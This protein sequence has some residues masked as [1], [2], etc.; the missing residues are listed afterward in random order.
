MREEKRLTKRPR[1]Q[2]AQV[3]PPPLPA[4]A[5]AGAAHGKAGASRTGKEDLFCRQ[6]V[7][8][9]KEPKSRQRL[10]F[11]GTGRRTAWWQPMQ[12]AEQ[13]QLST[14]AARDE[15]TPGE[16]FL[17]LPAA[18]SSPHLPIKILP[19]GSPGHR[20]PSGLTPCSQA[21]RQPTEKTYAAINRPALN[22]STCST[23]RQRR[24]SFT[25]AAPAASCTMLRPECTNPRWSQ[26]SWKQRAAVEE[27][28][29]KD[30]SQTQAACKATRTRRLCGWIAVAGLKVL[31]VSRPKTAAKPIP[32]SKEKK[33]D[34]ILCF[35]TVSFLNPLNKAGSK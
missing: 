13:P 22:E 21:L 32:G 9:T 4:F 29:R 2:T 25:A 27:K 3:S 5:H 31:R 8:R 19:V 20:P 26:G 6:A 14:E 10:S 35:L 18:T 16:P 30:R 34:G 33:T 28:E 23:P 11:R 7:C 17:Q 15:E 1:G 24:W 12:R